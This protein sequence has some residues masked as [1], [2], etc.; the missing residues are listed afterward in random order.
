MCFGGASEPYSA[1]G[2]KNSVIAQWRSVF[3]QANALED[4]IRAGSAPEGAQAQL[5]A[6]RAQQQQLR[7]EGNKDP[8]FGV[9]T[10]EDVRQ[11]DVGVGRENIDKAFTQFNPDFFNN[12]RNTRLSF[13]NPEI[14]RQFGD[15]KGKLVAALAGRGTLESS[16]GNRTIS[17]VTRQRDEAKT[18]VANE[19]QDAANQLKGQVENSKS[20]LYSLNE[21]SADP[22]SVNARALGSA[23]A[24]VAPQTFSPLGDIFASALQPFTNYQNASNQRAPVYRSTVPSGSGSGAVVR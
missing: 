18:N 3:E 7:D 6:L 14:D 12:F 16:V 13:Y 23:S 2:G 8:S 1:Y 19:S 11:R 21:I 20:D 22:Q 4:Q 17:D 24:I 15:A 10:R 5:E 9:E